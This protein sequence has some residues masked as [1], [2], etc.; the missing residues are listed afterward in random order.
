MTAKASAALGVPITLTGDALAA[1]SASL[2]A[3]W[4]QRAT[5]VAEPAAKVATGTDP[6]LGTVLRRSELAKLPK[7]EPLIEGVLSTPAAVVLVGSWGVGKTF[8]ALAF[9]LSVA[10]GNVWLGRAVRRTKVL[11]VL[12]EGAYGFDDRVTAWELAWNKGDP[13]SDGDLK[14]IV[15]PDSLKKAA[16]WHAIQAEAVEFGAGFVVLDT[17]SSLAPD[18]HET[19]DAP[20]IMRYFTNLA[21]AINGTA[22]FV[23]HPGWN[24]TD[25]TRGGYQFEGNADEVLLATEVS[26]GSEMFTLLR[27]KVKEGA[28]GKILYLRRKPSRGSCIVE[29]TFADTASVPV[30]DKVLA[31]LAAYGDLGAS[32]PDL[33]RELEVPDTTKS[34]FYRQVGKLVDAGKVRREG[35]RSR[36]KYYLATGA[37]GFA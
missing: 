33:V 5:E 34:T 14:F 18:A 23:H 13:V 19:N 26:K 2:T 37:G 28:A 15:Q 35:S 7:I 4:S 31:V 6:A 11:Y 10:T 22:L 12:G 36:Y 21:T 20:L 17:L 1:V 24:N 27:K 8:L 16:T 29:E 25:R 9:A 32:G 30:A 3:D